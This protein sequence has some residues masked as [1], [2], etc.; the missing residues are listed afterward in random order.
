M[1]LVGAV[2]LPVIPHGQTVADPPHN[3][4]TMRSIAP[5]EGPAT[6]S[7]ALQ[8]VAHVCARLGQRQVASTRA[9]SN[10]LRELGYCPTV[11]ARIRVAADWGAERTTWETSPLSRAAA[12]TAAVTN[13]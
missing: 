11:W 12:L 5:S 8:S 3:C 9:T 10:L 7:S 4:P 13:S 2:N 1:Y 6:S